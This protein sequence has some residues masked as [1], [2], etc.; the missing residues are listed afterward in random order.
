MVGMKAKQF[1][2]PVHGYIAMPESYCELFIDTPI[3]QRLKHIEQTSIRSLY[4]SARHDRFVHS[5]GV[6]HLAS[7]AFA[8]IRDNTALPILHGLPLPDYETAFRVA[9]LMHD[10]AHSPFSHTFEAYY[11]RQD[12]AK[13]FVFK[14]VDDEFKADYSSLSKYRGA[15]KAHEIFSAAVFLKY[16]RAQYTS[17]CQAIDPILVAR[18]ITGC[19]HWEPKSGAEQFENC[20]I[21]LINGAGIDVDK[22]DYILRDT[23]ASGV[24]NVSIDLHRL[25]GALEVVQERDGMKV[26]FRKS[27]LSVVKSVLDGRNFLYRWLYSHHTVVYYNYVLNRALLALDQSLSGGGEGTLIDAIFSE[28]SYER[29]VCV[30]D[31]CLYL[32]CDDDIFSLLKMHG[33]N[34]PHVKE[35]M[36]RKPDLVPLWKTQAEFELIF[37]DKDGSKRAFI[38]DRV[39]ERLAPVL[40]VPADSG[41]ILV[42]P[43]TPS[44]ISI[45]ESD[46]YIWILD[47][48]VT[49]AELAD[50]CW[51]EVGRERKNVSF[52]YVYVPRQFKHRVNDCIQALKA[53]V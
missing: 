19:T 23:W 30:G 32:P 16:F 37:K 43:V 6:F 12:R 2:D 48:V 7:I 40:G 5:L 46:L 26:A 38:Q 25:L 11:N 28:E 39:G 3:F 53:P 44:V 8:N 13:E 35:L 1:R 4:P 14:H 51:Q 36:S 29:A 27:A 20:L 9:A 15:P 47:R 49:F 18:M 31:C 21:S 52:F 17:L 34:V 22:L 41:D 42:L 10:C 24:N 45:E 50:A 33:A